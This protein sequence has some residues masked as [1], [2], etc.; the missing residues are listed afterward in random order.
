MLDG[1]RTIN[2]TLSNP[3]NGLSINVQ[4]PVALTI[5]DDEGFIPTTSAFARSVVLGN[6]VVTYASVTADGFTSAIPINSDSAGPAPDGYTITGP[7]Y[8]ITTS[9]TYTAPVNVCFNLPSITDQTTFSHLKVLHGET[10][11]N[12]QM[13]LVDRTTGLDFAS[14]TL[15]SSVSSL[16]PFV[17]AQSQSPTA[18]RSRFGG[19]LT[20]A[21]G[22]PVAGVNV[23]LSGAQSAFTLTDSLG[24]YSF[25]N[26]STGSTYIVT[27]SLVNYTFTPANRTFSLI[28]NKL[29]AVFT[30]I[31]DAVPSANP[32]DTS[33]FFVRQQYLDFLGREPDPNGLAFWTNEITSC[34]ATQACVDAKRINTSAAFFL[35][36]EFQDTGYLVYR[37][38]KSAYGNLPGAP[39]P[40][41]L[42]EFTPDTQQ[43]EQGVV[44]GVGDWQTQ[45]EINKNA[46]ALDFVNRSRFMTAYATTLTPSEFVD[47]L[48][49]NTGVT[50]SSTERSAAIGEFGAG[51]TSADPAARARALRRVAE[52][53]TLAQQ[54][55][56]RAFVLMQYFG[57]L[58]RNPN[59]AP[60]GDFAG[61]DF[62]VAKLTAAGGN[63]ITS[64]MVKSF[65]VSAEYRRRF[66]P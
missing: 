25:E 26:V 31:P 57:Y 10:D 47:G 8:D 50:P 4:S 13:V 5:I 54:E 6:V 15:C 21:P 30:A 46:F 42:N 61:Y 53:S 63:F 55:F 37:M 58:R 28:A 56:N 14:R 44:V 16:S 40:L 59:D 43:I 60:D 12:N 32:L 17:I 45:L 35:S 18:A 41:R 39:V 19:Q 48:Y 52:N 29:D 20:T 62:W 34:S 11:A 24:R 49:V 3:S 2:L 23:Q 38:Y 27:P 22:L 64:D 66:G 65:I 33:S 36:I 7:A 51:N 9:A 1:D